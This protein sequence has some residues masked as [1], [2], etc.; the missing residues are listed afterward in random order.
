MGGN[1][2]SGVN[3]VV[4]GVPSAL[5]H[6]GP[7][8]ALTFAKALTEFVRSPFQMWKDIATRSGEVAGMNFHY[9]K[10]LRIL[11]T[12]EVSG[13]GRWNYVKSH[14]ATTLMSPVIFGQKLVNIVTFRAAEI[15][16]QEQGHTGAEAVA[17]ANSAVRLSQSSSAEKDI[18][19]VQRSDDLWIRMLMSLA[20][21]TVALNNLVMPKRLTTREVAGSVS[22]ILMLTMTTMMAKALMDML[23]PVLEEKD[24]E[25]RKGLEKWAEDSEIPGAVYAMESVLDMVGTVP[26]AGRTVQSV[27]SERTPRY[28]SWAETAARMP[29]ATL[30]LLEDQGYTKNDVKTITDTVGLV[31]GIPTRHV[32]FGVGEAAHEVSNGNIDDGAWRWFQ[33]LALVRP[34]QKGE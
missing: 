5:T 4:T 21:Y 8:G 29:H 26:L 20:S 7:R 11:L 28:A 25:R 19:D 13:E 14:A 2:L 15:L 34:G 31:T 10:D 6:L 1:I 22:R 18:A 12:R 23:L 32:F 33:E 9:D 17:R 24:A 27:L 3:Q 16:A 30:K